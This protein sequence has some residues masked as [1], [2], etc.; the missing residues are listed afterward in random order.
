MGNEEEHEP[1]Q[2]IYI[3]TITDSDGDGIPDYK[4]DDD[5]NDGIPDLLD[6]DSDFGEQIP[7]FHLGVE[8]DTPISSAVSMI[9]KLREYLEDAPKQLILDNIEKASLFK[10]IDSFKNSVI[11]DDEVETELSDSNLADDGIDLWHVIKSSLFGEAS[12][13]VDSQNKENDV[14]DDKV[15]GKSDGESGGF[16]NA[17]IGW[18]ESEH[19]AIKRDRK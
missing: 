15:I 9:S 13:A 19:K 16:V 2:G 7:E 4:D 5:D 18:M 10:V 17:F 1:L 11:E 3:D 12:E 6:L 8:E 14:T